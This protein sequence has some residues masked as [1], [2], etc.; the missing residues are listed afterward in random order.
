MTLNEIANTEFGLD[1]NQLGS[2]E[3]EWCQDEHDNQN[4]WIHTTR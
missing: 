3:Q 1:Y 4:Y 2:G